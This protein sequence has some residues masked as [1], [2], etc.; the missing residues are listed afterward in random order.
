MGQA[1]DSH[2]FPFVHVQNEPTHTKKK[3][4]RLQGAEKSRYGARKGL[5]VADENV[6][7]AIV[8]GIDA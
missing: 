1:S 3:V 4:I 7:Q 8:K 2:N 6:L 5:F